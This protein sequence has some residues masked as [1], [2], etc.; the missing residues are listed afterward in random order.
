MTDMANV[1]ASG[2]S[3]VQLITDADIVV[4]SV[5]GLLLFASVLSW[6][7]IIDRSVRI[8][9]VRR[10][11]R[12]FDIEFKKLVLAKTFD[13]LGENESTP[14][15]R[16]YD[17]AVGEWQDTMAMPV[18]AREGLRARLAAVL[19]DTVSDELDRLGSRLSVLATIGAVAPFV[20]LF[21]TVWG[22]MRS[23]SAIAAT[24]NTTLA[25]VAPG[26]AEALF[27]TSVGLF[28]AIPAVIGYNHISNSID[29]F[30]LRFAGISGKLESLMSRRADAMQQAR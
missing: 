25:V 26:I 27:A 11:A 3:I 17:A 29:Q 19:D 10:Q 12:V 28:A 14:F 1:G 8:A 18:V 2:L 13:V 15:S 6:A 16:I 23:F 4:K 5:L 21:G 9:I 22:I 7:I 30:E 20:G 24:Q